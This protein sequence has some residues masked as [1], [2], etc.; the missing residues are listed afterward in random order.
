MPKHLLLFGLFL[1]LLVAVFYHP[2]PDPAIWDAD[3]RHLAMPE[4]PMLQEK[5]ASKNIQNISP[6]EASVPESHWMQQLEHIYDQQQ[7][8][9]MLSALP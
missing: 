9:E 2:I 4:Y 8:K 1:V 3:S 6:T 7:A 5:A